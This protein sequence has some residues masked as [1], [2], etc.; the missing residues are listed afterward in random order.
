MLMYALIGISLVLV[1]VAGLQ[2][3]Y[4]FYI[5]RVY[6]ER[7]KYMQALEQKC[8]GLSAKLSDAELRIAEQDRVLA[9]LKMPVKDDEIWADVIGDS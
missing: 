4:M 8:A 5:D 1:G 7:R 9:S 3:M 2:F 6:R